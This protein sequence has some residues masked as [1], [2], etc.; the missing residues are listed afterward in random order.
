MEVM[1]THACM[2]INDML[3]VC[4]SE[5]VFAVSCV[6]VLTRSRCVLPLAA[7]S[8]WA[9]VV[10]W[11]YL[12]DLTRTSTSLASHNGQFARWLQTLAHN[13]AWGTVINNWF[14]Y[15]D[16][17][18]Y[19]GFWIRN[20]TVRTTEIE[21]IF[22]RYCFIII[23]YIHQVVH[24]ISIMRVC[25]KMKHIIQSFITVP[26]RIL[27]QCNVQST[28]SCLQISYRSHPNGDGS[29]SVLIE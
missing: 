18:R 10:V 23:Y 4:V 7:M 20:R 11:Q 13:A 16:S 19:N 25:I 17:W 22:I 21:T 28:R 2:I 5:W 12:C 29:R 1:R 26:A 6:S 9:S 27:H 24:F 14:A 8:L 3:C 15:V